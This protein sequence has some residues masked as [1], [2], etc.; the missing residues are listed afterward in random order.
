MKSRQEIESL[1]RQKLK[2]QLL[3]ILLCVMVISIAAAIILVNVI[4]TESTQSEK[5]DPPEILEGESVYNNYPIA[6]PTIQESQIQ[7]I[8]VTNKAS[9]KNDY[10]EGSE[11]IPKTSYMLSRDELAD[12]KFV[13]SYQDKEGKLHAYYPD[14]VEKEASFDYESL[15]SIEGNDGY[16]RIYK[17]TY[18]C[19]AIELPYFTDRIAFAP[20][21]EERDAQFKKFGLNSEDST[22][23]VFTYKYTEKDENGKSVEK[24]A[25]KKV[26]IGK[27][28]VTGIGY[29]FMVGDVVDGNVVYRPYV[30]NSMADYYNYA[31]LGFYSYV[32]S[33]LVSAGLAEDSSFEPYLTTDYKQWVNK[34]T[35][36]PEGEG[37]IPEIPADS[38]VVVY[39]D[40]FTPLE[41]K[42]DVP[43][44]EKEDGV[45]YD[46]DVSEENRDGY[47]KDL[48]EKVEIDLSNKKNYERLVNA[49]VGKKLG[50]FENGV[51]VTL[52]SDSKT[53]DFGEGDSLEYNYEIIEIEAILTD[54]ED[55]TTEGMTI[56]QNDL[57]RVAYYLTVG[58]NRVSNI[59][60]HGIVDLSNAAFA[61]QTIEALRA[62]AIGEL[63][64]PI[65]L[66]V[67]YTEENSVPMQIKYV[68]DEIVAIYDT[69]GKQIS[70]IAEDSLVYYRW[71]IS[72]NGENQGYENGY[73]DFSDKESEISQRL[74]NSLLGRELEKNLSITF[75]DKTAHCEFVMDFI[76][77]NVTEAEYFVTSELVSAFRFQNNSQRDPFYGESIYE[78]TADNKYSLYAINST[79]CEAVVK[80]LGGIGETTGS[81]QGLIG[82]E[83]VAVGITPQIKQDYGLYKNTIYFELPRG[84]IVRDSG[85]DETIDDY[86]QYSKLGF[87]LYISDEVY[88]TE[89][90]SYIRYVG[91]D[92]YDIVA[93]VSA[94][95]LAFL[96][97]NFVDFWARRS[98]MMF[99]VEYLESMKVEFLMEDLKGSYEFAIPNASKGEYTFE[100]RVKE[101][102]E[103]TDGCGCAETLLREILA[104][105][106]Y[107]VTTLTDIYNETLKN[108][109]GVLYNSLGDALYSKSSYDTAGVGY[110]REIMGILYATGYQGTLT[111]EEQEATLASSP[112]LMRISLKL[113]LKKAPNAS[114]NTYVYEFYRCDDRRIMVRLYEIDKE[115]NV[116]NGKDVTDFYVST[117]A[118]KKIV[119]N[120]FALLNGQRFDSETA[121]PDLSK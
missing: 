118:F 47:I 65:T 109:E 12:G 56:G 72:V 113:D 104:E 75:L 52:T 48:K 96:K 100:V 2:R 44:S 40:V 68:I 3:L 80:M 36:M 76:T 43:D 92:L 120:Y 54:S 64:G 73:V 9:Y 58:G 69:K 105:N 103:H 111:P 34:I 84:I 16:G 29:Y 70:R 121:Y 30:Y 13:L 117:F 115:G 37:E 98:L 50:R 33:I 63:L 42:L 102:C 24:L 114:E 32:N 106:G 7:T 1:S 6:Y 89:T 31:M 62:S 71:Y 86:D 61:A 85:D 59:P 91:S 87:T 46:S 19:V 14:I 35:G 101:S 17:L 21:G 97:Y 55:I 83:T 53:I 95:K 4:P 27:K 22:E 5:K 108:E 93:K 66:T 8:I 51:T 88:D 99:D 90:K 39:T 28:N 41:S 74:K 79:A 10:N 57:I 23:I 82:I 38:S 49:L 11:N 26:V 60:Y 18:L 15:Y 94:D 78:N 112:L 67:D 81:S 107:K 25:T 77:Y 116:F 20:E 119:G 45:I 110:F